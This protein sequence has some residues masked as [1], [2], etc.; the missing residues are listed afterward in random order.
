[1]FRSIQWRLVFMFVLLV[2]AVM[3]VFG[4][5]LQYRVIDFYHGMFREEMHTVFFDELQNALIEAAATPP[6]ADTLRQTM[7]TYA[8]RLGINSDRNYYVLD[9]V[10]NIIC[11]SDSTPTEKLFMTPNLIAARA[12]QVGDTNSAMSQYLDFAVLILSNSG[13]YIVYIRDNKNEM[14]R[15]VQEILIQIAQTLAIGVCFSIM[16]GFILS[17]TITKPISTLTRKAEGIAKGDFESRIEIKSGDEIGK[18]SVSFNNMSAIISRSLKEISQEKNKA[19]TILLYMNDGVVAFDTEQHIIHI[20]PIAS[21]MLDITDTQDVLFDELFEHLGADICISELIYLDQINITERYF[22]CDDKHFKAFFAVFKMDSGKI[23]GVVVVVH[24]VT[25]ASRLDAARREFV[26]NVSHE[27][28]TPLTTIRSYAET[29]LEENQTPMTQQF[30][31]V[32]LR[33]VER[34]TRI[35]K[36]LLT[37]SSLDN[38]STQDRRTEFSLNGLIRECVQKLSME[39]QNNGQNLSVHLSPTLPQIFTDRDRIEQV[40]TNIITNAIKYTGENGEIEVYTGHVYNGVYIRVL[41]NGIGIPEKDLPHIFERF[42]RVDKAR[43]REQGGTGL[44]LA[45]AR[46][47]LRL[48]GGSIKINSE[49]GVGTEVIIILP[50][51]SKS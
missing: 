40:I 29:L 50:I 1:M 14:M 36:D 23:G 17:K 32:I 34:M 18:L 4:T 11:G 6:V 24:D 19:E 21:E 35:V 43:A 31:N 47:I 3:I 22:S 38:D 28:R 15:I 5:F 51:V 2:V 25:T 13:E 42:Y 46:E 9:S 26:A 27:L 48:H 44:G 45:I 39:A 12:G 41:D 20:N 37:L 7:D 49:V 10:G 33:E 8:G 30:L 16:L